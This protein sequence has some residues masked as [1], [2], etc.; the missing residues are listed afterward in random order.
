LEDPEKVRFL[1][2]NQKGERKVRDVIPHDLGSPLEDPWFRINAYSAQDISRWKDL[3]SK[4]V[5]QIARDYF[6]TQD[7]DFLDDVWPAVKRA[8]GLMYR[9]DK[10]GDGM[11]ENEGFPDQTYDVWSAK[12]PSAYCGGLWLACLQAGAALAE[13]MGDDY[14][15]EEFKETYGR[16][17]SVYENLLW[18]GAYYNYEASDSKHR[19]SIMADQLAGHWFSK[20]CGLGGVVPEDHARSAL[21][22]VF[23]YNVM[24]YEGGRLGAMNGMRPDGALDRT[25]MQSLEIWTGTTF[26]VAAALLQ[27]G[28]TDMAFE[29][30]RG[31]YNMVYEDYGLWFQTPEALSANE[32]VRAISYMRPLAIWAIQWELERRDD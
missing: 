1:F 20:A 32:S 30:A 17:Q 9:F 12:G 27:A 10:D 22:T 18:N 31:V 21:E 5:L 23:K 4:F 6:L 29:T 14:L 25:G 24:G 7:E 26:A 13:V 8:I 11:I 16:A 19:D 2:S 28:L 15:V 3:N